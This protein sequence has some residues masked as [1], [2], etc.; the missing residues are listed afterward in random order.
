MISSRPNSPFKWASRPPSRSSPSR[1]SPSR[2]ARSDRFPSEE[3][4]PRPSY[5]TGHSSNVVAGPSRYGAKVNSTPTYSTNHSISRAEH[6]DVVIE[7]EAAADI[8]PH[9]GPL[10]QDQ[11][12]STDDVAASIS[13]DFG[14]PRSGSASSIN[15]ISNQTDENIGENVS[16]NRFESL[17]EE[18]V[19]TERSYVKRIDTLYQRYAVPLRQLAKDRDTAIIPVYEAQRLFGNLGEVLGANM[20]FLKDL[21]RFLEIRSRSS[22]SDLG[23]IVYRNVS[24]LFCVFRTS[25]SNEHDSTQ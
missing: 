12:G 2:T 20:A 24:E 5:S 10:V 19:H 11:S 3:Q 14:M 9:L 18:L 7:S 22:T 1:S 17:L 8:L 13:L 4:S 25:S 6:Y 16:S 21:E 15:A 23:D